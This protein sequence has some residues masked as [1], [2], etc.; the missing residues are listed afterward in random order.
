[1]QSTDIIQPELVLIDG[2]IPPRRARRGDA[3]LDLAIQEDAI[4]QPN[5]TKY[6]PAGVKL[7]L[8]N[9]FVGEVISRSSTARRGLC[10]T[11]TAIDQNYT[12]EISSIVMNY[13]DKPIEIKKGDHLAQLI[14]KQYYLFA[15]EDMLGLN[16][17]RGERLEQKF[18]SS[19]K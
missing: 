18:G 7:K 12:G 1:M 9:G 6:F 13:T 14:L 15:N 17:D 4:V 19:G 16:E 2:K 10:V 8:P 11:S 3:G 5:E